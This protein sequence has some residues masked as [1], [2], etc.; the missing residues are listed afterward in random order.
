MQNKRNMT[1]SSRPNMRAYQA[2]RQ[3]DRQFRNYDTSYIQPKKSKVPT[4]V[5]IIVAL[6]VIALIVFGASKLLSGCSGDNSKLLSPEESATVVVSPGESAAKIA[7]SLVDAR[8]IAKQKDFTNY[9]SSRDLGSKLQA[10]TYLFAGGTSA[11]EIAEA[12]AKGATYEGE[13]LAIPEGYK[14]SDIAAAVETASGGRITAAQF[15]SAASDASVYASSYPFLSGAGTNSLEGFLF[16]K[17]YRVMPDDTADSLI[18]VMLDQF[19]TETSGLDL[20]Y[21]EEQGLSFYDVVK[22]ASIVEKESTASTKGMVAG[23]FYNRLTRED[24]AT[25]GY[26]Q[27][28][29]TTAYEVGHDPTADEVHAET[30]YSTYTNQG[31][32][33][34]PICSP[35]IESLQAVCNP[36]VSDYFYFFFANDEDGEIQYYFSETYEEHQEAIAENS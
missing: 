7:D 8:L 6:I 25:V 3:G 9:V 34:T 12:M 20:S 23:V 17:T 16:P 24:G 19:N 2:H 15:T 36:D 1:Y 31:L 5:G 22:L 18:R 30:P 14:L 26:L 27:S 11:G 29:A 13:P 33:P 21:P 35:S 10:G 28:D 32:P 4:I